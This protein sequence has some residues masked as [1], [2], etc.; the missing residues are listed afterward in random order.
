MDDI[1]I[2]L[3]PMAGITDAAMREICV[4]Q[5]AGLA[6]TEMVS[7]KGM[8]YKNKKTNDLL[9]PG[10]RE[11]KIGVQLFGSDAEILADTAKRVQDL[12]RERLHTID[13]NMGCPAAKIVNNGEGCAL[14]KDPQLASQIILKV[15]NA[16]DK[17]A[18]VSVKFRKGWD[19]AHSNAV[20]F[21]KM[22]EESGAD[23]IA[24]H[25]RT[26]AQ[27]YSG[28]ADW[29]V[30]AAVKQAVTI[31]VIGNG[32]IFTAYDARDMLS[33]TRC[34]AVMVA[35]GAQ[36]NPFLFAQIAELLREGMVTTQPTEAERIDMCLRQARLA[37]QYKGEALAMLQMRT[38]APHYTKGMKGAARLRE[39]LVRV[40]TYRELQEIFEMIAQG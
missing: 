27:F 34:D 4:E 23:A 17:D 40:Q 2:Y 26:R 7:A 31:K 38:H 13:I 19:E 10:P 32:D 21:A 12:H 25:G 1:K 6:F 18:V 39:K 28:S 9:S 3:A 37:I 30:I 14:M 8:A 15:R 24:V 22:A 16:V 29:D 35:R 33:K 20:Q 36:G 11:K 5:G